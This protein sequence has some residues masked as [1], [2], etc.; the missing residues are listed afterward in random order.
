MTQ[1]GLDIFGQA[2]YTADLLYPKGYV[3]MEHHKHDY[4]TN[5][6]HYETKEEFEQDWNLVYDNFGYPHINPAN[7]IES[8]GRENCEAMIGGE[9]T[10][11]NLMEIYL[12]IDSKEVERDENK[13]I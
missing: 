7:V 3:V 5:F 9:K 8:Y 11:L 13:I 10:Y 2:S 1:R 4:F 12:K 6:Y